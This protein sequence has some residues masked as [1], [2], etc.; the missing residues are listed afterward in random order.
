MKHK[1]KQN[2]SEELKWHENIFYIDSGHWTS[3]PL[4]AGR[5]RHW[6]HFAVLES[7][8]YGYL[9][10]YLKR[11]YRNNA[12]VL[13]APVG[14]GYH[15][16]YLRGIHNSVHGLDISDVS[17]KKCPG[18]I[19]KKQGDIL[20]SG[21]EDESFDIIICSQFLHHVH[22]VGF[23]PFIEE[24][25]RLLKP[26]GTL[27]ILE[28]SSFFPFYWLTGLVEYFTGNVTGKVLTERPISP[29]ELTSILKSVKLKKI[30][31]RGLSFNHARFP[32]AMQLILN[33]IDYPLRRV[34]PFK[35]FSGHIGWFCEKPK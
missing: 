33:L 30:C 3:N 27:A 32:V 24:Y 7:R 13:L 22:E 12:R 28:P 29:L 25:C 11:K 34:Y 2:I 17:L 19:I 14:D 6:L 10:K 4:F 21:Y 31:Y 20:H 1:N 26:G 35:L 5:E 15:Y 8:F 16:K 23:S 9:N 18:E